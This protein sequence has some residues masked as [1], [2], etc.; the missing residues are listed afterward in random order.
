MAESNCKRR[1]REKHKQEDDEIF[2]R[3]ASY[4]AWY[5]R[6]KIRRMN[7][8]IMLCYMIATFIALTDGK[9]EPSYHHHVY[10]VSFSTIANRLTDYQF[11]QGYRMTK[12]SFYKLH[13]IL[14]PLLVKEFYPEIG[15]NRDPETN[16]YLIKTD[17]HLSIAIGNFAGSRAF[18]LIDTINQ[19]NELAFSFPNYTE[20]DTIAPLLKA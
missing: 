2:A 3:M 19:C 9:V 12:P 4:Q 18:D 11:Q 5:Q 7:L 20:Q 17:I 15:G 13:G 14:K 16:D 1:R 8:T 10:R 6:N